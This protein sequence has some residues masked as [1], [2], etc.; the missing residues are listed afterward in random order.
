MIQSVWQYCDKCKTNTSHKFSEEDKLLLVCGKC[1]CENK[2][3]PP[4][5]R[6]KDE[7][8]KNLIESKRK[9]SPIEYEHEIMNT[10]IL[11]PEPHLTPV[12]VVLPKLSELRRLGMEKWKKLLNKG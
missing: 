3:L 1:K 12:Q 2:V 9:I 6:K 4:V 10:S 11:V 7:A 8:I 5:N